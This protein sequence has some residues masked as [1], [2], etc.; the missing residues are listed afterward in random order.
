MVEQTPDIAVIDLEMP[1]MNGY[2]TIRKLRTLYP[3][4]KT[5]AFSGFLNKANQKRAIEMGAHASISK[6]ESPMVFVDAMEAVIKGKQ[7]HSDV[8]DAYYVSPPDYRPDHI[9]EKKSDSMLTLREK[10]ILGL[11]ARGKTSREI[12]QAFNISQ[13]TVDKHRSNIRTKLGHKS[14]AETVRYAIEWGYINRR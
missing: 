1:K 9:S 14:L 13:W 7:Y 12:G 3:E 10:Q 8:S 2:E 5:I 6:A 11:I 4:T